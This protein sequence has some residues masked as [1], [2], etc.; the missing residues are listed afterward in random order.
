[1]CITVHLHYTHWVSTQ[2]IL[3]SSE[4]C[5]AT[6]DLIKCIFRGRNVAQNKQDGMFTLI[7]SH[8]TFPELHSYL[9][10]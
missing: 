8:E 2:L 6:Q 1:M 9:V 5:N 10:I 3:D 7:H 4:C